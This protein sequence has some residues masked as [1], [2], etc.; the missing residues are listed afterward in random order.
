MTWREA[1]EA[2]KR[3]DEEAT[4]G[5]WFAVD[6]DEQVGPERYNKAAYR[7]DQGRLSPDNDDSFTVSTKP[8][9]AGWGTDGGHSGYC[10]A[11][12]E[13]EFIAHARTDLP[14]LR[15][16]AEMLSKSY[17]DTFRYAGLDE[18]KAAA[19]VETLWAEAKKK[20]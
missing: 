6:G 9:A 3:R 13:A 14:A 16:F 17:C 18:A 1:F 7:E 2:M 19:W 4:P 5:P 15:L 10:I 8:K 11:R 12:T 20:P